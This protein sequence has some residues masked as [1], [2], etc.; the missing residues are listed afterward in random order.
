MVTD[1]CEPVCIKYHALS[2]WV[3]TELGG[4]AHERRVA[5]IASAIFDLTG[6]L[7]ELNRAD[8]RLLRMAAVVHDVGR[9]VA[10]EGHPEHG[11]RMV[12]RHP[13]LPLTR[14]ERRRLAFLTRY[15]KGRVP[16]PGRDQ[17][18]RRKDNHERMR[19][20]LALRRA[21]DALDGRSTETPRLRFAMEGRRL[22]VTC[23]LDRDTPKARRV[24]ARRK[25]FRLLEELLDCR[26]EVV[27][28]RSKSLRLVA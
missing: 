3:S 17:I 9:A 7:H 4:I 20:L 22:L 1:R 21:A 8:L 23:Q 5:S 10:K 11:A 6:S 19:L 27:L 2:R 16:A 18:L 13:D 15:H 28:P 25:K 12:R 14:A 24:Y 26:V